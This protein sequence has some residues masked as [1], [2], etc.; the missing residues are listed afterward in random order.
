MTLSKIS[1]HAMGL[2]P[3]HILVEY[4]SFGGKSN[5]RTQQRKNSLMTQNKMDLALEFFGGRGNED[6]P[7]IQGF[8]ENSICHNINFVPKFF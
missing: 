3:R 7:A 6:F 2:K 5:T 8:F 4:L 1:K